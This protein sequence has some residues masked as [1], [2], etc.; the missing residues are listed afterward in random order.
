MQQRAPHVYAWVERMNNP[1]PLSGEFLADDT[2][3]DTLLPILTTLCKDQLP[4]VLDAIEHNSAWLDANRE[5]AFR[6]FS[7]CTVSPADLPR[8]SG[9]SVAIHSGCFNDPGCTTS[10]WGERV[11]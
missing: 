7:G 1:K 5:A 9:A 11:G 2:V 4:D 10:R 3:P 8:E 6:G